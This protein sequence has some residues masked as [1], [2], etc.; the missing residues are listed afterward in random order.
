LRHSPAAQR[1]F[2]RK[3]FGEG[4]EH[5]QRPW[6]AHRPRWTTTQRTWQFFTPDLRSQ[7]GKWDPLQACEQMMPHNAD[8]WPALGRDQYVEAHTLL[9]GYLLSSQGDRMA[10]ASSIE[11]RFPFLDHRVIEFANRL[12]TH[13]K[14][15]GLDEKHL[16]KRCAQGLVAES[17]RQRSKQPY[18]APDSASFFKNGVAVDYVAE[19][20]SETSV[21]AAGYFDASAVRAL[22]DKC[23][24]GKAIGF[25]D[26]MA[27]V[28]VLSTMLLHESFILGREPVPMGQDISRN[29]INK[30]AVHGR[31]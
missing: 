8:R 1:G 7:L 23:A 4:L 12:P 20:L 18:R 19:L 30:A 17:V 14:I 31:G 13:F 25:G 27:F 2:T 16:L 11:A 10:M 5:A 21:R 24:A 29:I 3:F 28:G 26:N 9:S 15:R 6:F 22:T